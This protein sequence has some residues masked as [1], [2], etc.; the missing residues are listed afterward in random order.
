MGNLNTRM[1]RELAAQYGAEA[2]QIIQ[3]GAYRTPSG[4]LVNIADLL[5]RAASGTVSYPPDVTLPESQIGAYRTRITIA[6]ETTLAAVQR[7]RAHGCHPA[8]L[9]FA[10]ATHP[11]GGFRSGA[12]AQEEYL[13]RSSGLY[14]CLRPNPMYAFHRARHDP[15]YTDYVIYSPAVPVFRGDDGA[16]L[17]TPYTVGIITSPAVNASAL[18]R[19]RHAEIL[20]AMWPRIL[21]VLAV[22]VRHG[23]DSIVLGAWGCGAF[24]NDSAAIAPL[25]RKAL[26]ENFSGAYQQVSFAIVDRSP[27]KRNIGPFQR[28]F[29]R[30]ADRV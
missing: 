5:E 17:E 25:F 22:G 29:G 24:G 30:G 11:G 4:R 16:L 20:P 13:A 28:A 27:E 3:D 8:A 23:H 6:K 1:P 26:A 18:P 10:S 15:L 14:A 9:N 21:K 7:L 12:R 2:V 19:E